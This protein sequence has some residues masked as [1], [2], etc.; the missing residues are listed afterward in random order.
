MI[1]DVYLDIASDQNDDRKIGYL[2][3]FRSSLT[4]AR[5]TPKH[6]MTPDSN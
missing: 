2:C 3:L 6:N 5:L 4:I 1:Q